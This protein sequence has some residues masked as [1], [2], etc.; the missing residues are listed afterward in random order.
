MAGLQT[1][2]FAYERYTSQVS[3][4]FS[5]EI[6]YSWEDQSSRGWYE[7]PDMKTSKAKTS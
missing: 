4:L 6:R 7:G 1:G 2:G 5:P 3:C